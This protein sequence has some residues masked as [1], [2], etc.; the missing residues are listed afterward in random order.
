VAESVQD[1][2]KIPYD[3]IE[4]DYHLLAYVELDSRQKLRIFSREPVAQ[5]TRYTLADSVRL[6]PTDDVD[7][8]LG[9]A[10]AEAVPAIPTDATFGPIRLLG[11]EIS[12]R[13]VAPGE[14]VTLTLFWQADAR[15]PTDLTVFTHIEDSR[16]WGQNDGYP[17]CGTRPTSQWQSGDLIVE[18]RDLR[19]DPATPAGQY[20]IRVGL[21]DVATGQR[22]PATGADS[23][24]GDH[25]VLGTLTV[26]P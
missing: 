2:E 26:G 20:P 25:A 18:S 12:R 4:R 17:A 16:I 15:P 19:L 8:L 6:N 11:Y 21:Y 1:E 13:S 9:Q 22:S 7:F 10:L 5:P 3:R 14:Y 24:A 23:E